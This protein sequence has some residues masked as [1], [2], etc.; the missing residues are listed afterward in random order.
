VNLAQS[1]VCGRPKSSPTEQSSPNLE[2]RITVLDTGNPRE[3]GQTLKAKIK[4]GEYVLIE[5]MGHCII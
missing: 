5:T 2:F 3:L 1:C 4:E